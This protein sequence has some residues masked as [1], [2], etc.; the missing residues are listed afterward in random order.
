MSI[1]IIKPGI[2]SAVQDLGRTGY[3]SLGIGPGGVMDFFAASVANYLVG[4][5]EKAAVIEMHFPA[6]TILFQSDALIS[7]TGA[8]F[9]AHLNDTPVSLYQPIFITKGAILSFKKN[10]S[11][12]RAY[13]AI[14]GGLI[15]DQWLGSYSTHLKVKAGG[16]KGRLLQKDDLIGLNTIALTNR[17]KNFSLALSVIERMYTNEN[18]IRC[19]AGPEYHLMNAASEN[20][21]SNASFVISNQSDRMGYRL[22]GEALLLKTPMELISSPVGFG[23]IQLL[24]NGQ[25]IVLMAD[26]QTTGGY[27]RIASVI[28][29][30]LPRLAQLPVNTVIKVKLITLSKAEEILLSVHQTINEIKKGCQKFYAAH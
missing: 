23:T 20:I 5:D 24:P 6:A 2:C 15:I 30:D 22:Q 13:I 10:C 8:D 27:P 7:I 18:T 19:I 4:N 17:N 11:G 28:T 16:F 12:V 1:T 25:L 9:D 14:S 21:F 3:R 26:H 29:A